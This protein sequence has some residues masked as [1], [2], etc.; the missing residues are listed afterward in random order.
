[1]VVSLQD[2]VINVCI[3]E[4]FKTIYGKLGKDKQH[5][6]H[7]TILIHQ[8]YTFNH[9]NYYVHCEIPNMHVPN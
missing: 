8:V 9:F 5:N 7:F 1:M 2:Y 3:R 6:S 4:C